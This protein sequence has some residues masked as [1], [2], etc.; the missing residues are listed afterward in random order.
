MR[1]AAQTTSPRPAK[2]NPELE[3]KRHYEEGA[4]AEAD[5]EYSAAPEPAFEPRVVYRCGPSPPAAAPAKPCRRTRVCVAAAC[6]KQL[7]PGLSAG[8]PVL[9]GFS[10]GADHLRKQCVHAKRAP[11]APARARAPPSPARYPEDGGAR[12]PPLSDAELS[13]LC[14]PAGVAPE[15]LRRSPS[16]SA[17][18]EVVLG[19]RVDGAEQC[20]VFRLKAAGNFPLYGVCWHVREMLHRAPGLAGGRYRACRAPFR[21]CMIAAPRCY[22]LVTHYPFFDLHFRVGGRAGRGALGG[23]EAGGGL[24]GPGSCLCS[25]AHAAPLQALG[26]GRGRHEGASTRSL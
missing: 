15:K 21:S 5:R 24:G 6:A 20:F 12:P 16:C 23:G 14:F 18:D 17:L 9:R 26:L 22:C 1:N 2:P 19:R 25:F 4:P 3:R 13:A 10:T 11:R 8:T 7:E